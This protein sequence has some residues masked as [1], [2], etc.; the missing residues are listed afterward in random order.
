M[1]GIEGHITWRDIEHSDYKLAS[2]A[3]DKQVSIKEL[4]PPHSVFSK[5]LK[6]YVHLLSLLYL[7]PMYCRKKLRT[8]IKRHNM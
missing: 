6:L 8:G 4:Q 2:G 3:L 5:N 7:C 1:L